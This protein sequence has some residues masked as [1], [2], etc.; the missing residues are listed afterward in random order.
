MGL[1]ETVCATVED[2]KIG[3]AMGHVGGRVP[4]APK[5]ACGVA[6]LGRPTRLGRRAGPWAVVA[7]EG[8]PKPPPARNPTTANERDFSSNAGR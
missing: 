2:P 7:H 4:G 1:T 3:G 5:G 8:L 6:R